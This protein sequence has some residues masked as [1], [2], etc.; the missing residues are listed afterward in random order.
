[1]L[2]EGAVLLGVMTIGQILVLKTIKSQRSDWGLYL[3]AIFN[4]H[5]GTGLL[6]ATGKLLNSLLLPYIIFL[7]FGSLTLSWMGFPHFVPGGEAEVT[8]DSKTL[9]A[10]LRS[11]MAMEPCLRIRTQTSLNFD[12]DQEMTSVIF[13]SLMTPTYPQSLPQTRRVYTDTQPLRTHT[14][15]LKPVLLYILQAPST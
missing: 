8:R 9:M 6:E 2:D 11:E 12:Q 4:G 15:I 14:H 13:L 1:M 10:M 3:R 5:I 7:F